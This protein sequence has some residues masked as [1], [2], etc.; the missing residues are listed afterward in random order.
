MKPY[1]YRIKI[2]ID[3]FLIL[4]LISLGAAGEWYFSSTPAPATTE[5]W[6]PATPA[7]QVAVIPKQEIKPP[8]VKVYA[9]V[10][11]QTLHLPDEILNDP[12]K[13]ILQA[14]KLPSDTHPATVTTIIDQATGEVQTYIR[15][16]PLP[17]FA[18]EQTGEARID[19]G[20]KGA[21]T[22]GR[23]SVREDLLQVKGFHA[24][25]NAG[26]D[27]DGEIF[28]GVGVGYRW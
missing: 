16:E 18:T 8:K 12:N 10:A 9:A 20:L 5:I 26:L 6:T 4:L 27:S 24:G 7:K 11:K 19:V 23:L 14:T 28:V 17:W 2:V 21:S 15:R 22:V 25:I 3:A 13:Y 1:P